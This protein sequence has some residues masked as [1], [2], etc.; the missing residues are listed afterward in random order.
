L[1]AVRAGAIEFA[2]EGEVGRGYSGMW[3]FARI[4]IDDKCRVARV[5]ALI[6]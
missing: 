2:V 3:D 6:V 5:K 1:N 4:E